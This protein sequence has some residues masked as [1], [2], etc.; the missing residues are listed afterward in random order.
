M[1]FSDVTVNV[2]ELSNY[3]TRYGNIKSK[4]TK[5]VD[6]ETLAKRWNIDLGKAKKTVAQMTQ[7]GVQSFLHPTLGH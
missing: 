1:F 3:D 5:Q 2:S 7:H 6:S 4:K